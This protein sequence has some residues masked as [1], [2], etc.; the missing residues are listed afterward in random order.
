MR[1]ALATQP[2]SLLVENYIVLTFEFLLLPGTV[3]NVSTVPDA[4]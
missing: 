4:S 3:V 1:Q 2:I